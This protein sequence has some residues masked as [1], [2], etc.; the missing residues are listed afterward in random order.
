MLIDLDRNTT[1]N[2]LLK[3]SFLFCLLFEVKKSMYILFNKFNGLL[4]FYRRFD[5]S[6]RH[7]W[8]EAMEL[9]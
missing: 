5:R 6:P 7:S 4:D 2:I 8:I 1:N 3:N 9:S